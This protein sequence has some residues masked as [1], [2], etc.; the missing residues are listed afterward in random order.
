[1]LPT[2]RTVN[3]QIT[4]VAL[5]A[6]WGVILAMCRLRYMLLE[7]NMHMVRLLLGVSSITWAFG[8]FLEAH[9][10]TDFRPT[11]YVMRAMMGENTWGVLFL[12]SGVMCLVS[13]LFGVRNKYTVLFDAL[14]MCVVWTAS[15]LA[16]LAAWW[17]HNIT[18]WWSQL[19][20]YSPPVAISGEVWLTL[21]AWWHF[22]RQATDR[23]IYCR[24]DC[25]SAD[26][27]YRSLGTEGRVHGDT[28][29]SN[30]ISE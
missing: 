22:V 6:K 4:G 14:L 1:M 7:E 23:R 25:T 15:T 30:S 27:P 10:F 2:H 5:G 8:L 26:C 24:L 19:V 12:V 18:G 9:I 17:P 29:D 28:R 16:C 3:E 11:Y 20:A 21:A 13:L